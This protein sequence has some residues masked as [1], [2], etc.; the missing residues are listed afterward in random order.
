MSQPQMVEIVGGLLCAAWRPLGLAGDS[1]DQRSTSVA[2]HRDL[3]RRGNVW[4]TACTVSSKLAARVIYGAGTR[5][6]QRLL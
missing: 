1:G 6:L 3:G 2:A 5:E 4:M